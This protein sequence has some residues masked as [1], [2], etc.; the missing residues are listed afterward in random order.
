MTG[1]FELLKRDII[2]LKA[3]R[4]ELL[5]AAKAAVANYYVTIWQCNDTD[6]TEWVKQLEA[7]IKKAEGSA[8]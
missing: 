5:K 1:T 2:D 7:A 3:Q 4:D 8:T 6:A